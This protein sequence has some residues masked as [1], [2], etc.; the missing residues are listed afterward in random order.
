[1]IEISR[2]S[3]NEARQRFVPNQYEHGRT[4]RDEGLGHLRPNQ[5]KGKEV[6]ISEESQS[7]MIKP[8][9]PKDGQWKRNEKSKP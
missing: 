9:N 5:P 1:M 3:P 6:V 2:K 8:K 7:R 4:Q